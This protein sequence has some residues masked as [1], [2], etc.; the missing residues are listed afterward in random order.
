[1]KVGKITVCMKTDWKVVA[2]AKHSIPTFQV[3]TEIDFVTWQTQL[4][5]MGQRL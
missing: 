1:M 2:S 5:K 3:H 4:Q